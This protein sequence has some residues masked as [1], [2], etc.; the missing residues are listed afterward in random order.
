MPKVKDQERSCNSRKDRLQE[1]FEAVEH[2]SWFSNIHNRYS[3]VALQGYLG[4]T[5]FK[6]WVVFAKIMTSRGSWRCAGCSKQGGNLA[7]S[8]SPRQSKGVWQLTGSYVEWD[9]EGW[10]SIERKKPFSPP[11]KSWTYFFISGPVRSGSNC[12]RS[13]KYMPEAGGVGIAGND[14][15][16]LLEQL[17]PWSGVCHCVCSFKSKPTIGRFGEIGRISEKP[18]V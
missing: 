8:H 3:V 16:A 1:L 5:S 9:P 18:R 7:R 2:N 6:H 10:D 15:L 17:I 12:L 4:E 14:R 13:A 11:C